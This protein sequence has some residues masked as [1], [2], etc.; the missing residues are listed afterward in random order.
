MAIGDTLR[1]VYSTM[2]TRGFFP[3]H[4]C[5]SCGKPACGKC[6]KPTRAT[7]QVQCPHRRLVHGRTQHEISRRLR[8][9]PTAPRLHEVR[10]VGACEFHHAAA[11]RTGQTAHVS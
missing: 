4:D 7:S 6:G 8:R 5:T 3:P 9:S 11:A 1:A 2:D 10:G